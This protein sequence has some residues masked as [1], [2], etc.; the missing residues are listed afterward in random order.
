MIFRGDERSRDSTVLKYYVCYY[1]KEG[2][3]QTGKYYLQVVL[4][5]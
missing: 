2:P 4:G 5:F 1:N 3:Y